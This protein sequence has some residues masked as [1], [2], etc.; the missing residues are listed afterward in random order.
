MT[1]NTIELSNSFFKSTSLG[2]LK[3]PLHEEKEKSGTKSTRLQNLVHQILADEK[4]A[5]EVFD[6][7]AK[8]FSPDDLKENQRYKYLT[9][10][11]RIALGPLARK[12]MG[13][14]TRKATGESSNSIN[15]QLFSSLSIEKKVALCV[16]AL[17]LNEVPPC[18]NH[19]LWN[20]IDD[21]DRGNDL[22]VELLT[23]VMIVKFKEQ[24]G[25]LRA[26]RSNIWV[27]FF[28]MRESANLST[29]AVN[30][31]ALIDA[32]VLTIPYSVYRGFPAPRTKEFQK[33]N[34][35][36]YL[37]IIHASTTLT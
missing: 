16:A 8:L 2:E 21:D 24:E 4:N 29:D 7:M 20:G 15:P 18:F 34:L 23:E 33:Y 13:L 17:D 5:E 14:R 19:E 36:S 3:N 35:T 26:Q 6:E 1:S 37:T 32:L 9:P 27:F 12:E 25:H 30:A 22:K 28:E 31:M 10:K 11:E